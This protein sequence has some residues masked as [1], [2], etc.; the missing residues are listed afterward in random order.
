MQEILLNIES[1]ETRCAFLKHGQLHDLTVERKRTRR[2]TGNIYRGRV[3]SIL[4]NI[5]SA[6]I[7]I[8]EGENGFIH[9][10][11]ILEN[12]KKLQAMY[13]IDIEGD[14]EEEAKGDIQ[15]L[16]KIDE[17]V[18][19]QV[20]K[21]PIGTKGARLTS[22]ISIAGR[23]LVLLPNTPHTGVSRRIE[24]ASIRDK[25]KRLIRS[26]DLPKGMGVI[27]R[28]ACRT[29]SRDLLLDE[30]KELVAIWDSIMEGYQKGQR[31]ALLY[32]ESDLLKQTLMAAVNKRVS[33]LL[34]DDQPTFQRAKQAYKQYAG[35]H[36]LKIEL[37]RD[38]VPMFERF[39]VEREIDKAMRKKVWIAG[40]AYLY[41]DRTE[42]M[43]TIDVNSGRSTSGDSGKNVE[44][45]IV[46]VNLD[47]A[48]E[49]ARQL[50]IRNIGGLVICDF[51]DMRS[52]KNARRVMERL[53][54]CMKEDT[55]KCT[56]LPMS[57]F[58]LVE[59]T[60]Q[61]TRESLAQTL[62]NPCPYC[63]GKGEIKSM[64][65]VTIEMERALKKALLVEEQYGITATVH[66]A[67]YNYLQNGAA[68]AIQK[69]M[70]ELN[71][72]VTFG[73]DDLLHLNDVR[74]TSTITGE[75]LEL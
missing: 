64:E 17:P 75:V 41:F 69:Q 37:Y 29:A 7:D 54:D 55:A 16:L 24:E 48:E 13:D 21:E 57:E 15:Q 6:F 1:K 35:E 42:A 18:L 62:L 66:P 33:R 43:Y 56:V 46:Q 71:G 61:R 49:I 36:P 9:I 8:N 63:S 12:R 5:Q 30:A 3:K 11:D 22:K 28:T 10:D 27:C 58:C 38:K 70:E 47:A 23:Y 40:G 14:E 67:L 39:G 32:E 60:R 73:Q 74:Y 44:E 20:V 51:I 52:R 4:H 45:T 31:P 26:F 25:L 72:Q 53:R 34:I 19:V 50:R 59:L 2:V 68:N 65:S